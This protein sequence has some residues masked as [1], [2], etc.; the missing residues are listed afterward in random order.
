MTT[1]LTGGLRRP[2]RGLKKEERKAKNNQQPNCP[3]TSQV[4]ATGG[5]AHEVTS[6]LASEAAGNRLT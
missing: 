2:L 5:V 6:N 4:V 3:E 1:W